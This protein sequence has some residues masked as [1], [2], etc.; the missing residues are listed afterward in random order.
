[1]G[2]CASS[3]HIVS[4]APCIDFLLQWPVR[5]P[6]AYPPGLG[7]GH[8]ICRITPHPLSSPPSPP[9][10]YP[11]SPETLCIVL[12]AH[13][14]FLVEIASLCPF[15][16]LIFGSYLMILEFPPWF[17]FESHFSSLPVQVCCRPH[18]PPKKSDFFSRQ[19]STHKRT[20]STAQHCP[21]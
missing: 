8:T 17:S 5:P 19:K 15:Y 18:P 10:Y 13:A 20:S 14:P 21:I 12:Q 9:L 16:G 2:A 7:L 6:P 3:P 11:P 4:S 1:M